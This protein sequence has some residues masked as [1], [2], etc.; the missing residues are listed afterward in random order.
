M[1]TVYRGTIRAPAQVAVRP[2]AGVSAHLRLSGA[3][4]REAQTIAGLEH[5]RLCRWRYGEENDR[6]MV[7]RLMSGGSLADR[8]Q[9]GAL[10]LRETAEIIERLAPALDRAHRQGIVHRDLKP[11]NILF[12]SDG[13]PYISDFGLAKLTEPSA[14][15]SQTGVMGTP[16]YMAPEQARGEKTIDGRA[17]LYALGVIVYQ[18]LTGRPPFDADTPMGV[19]YKHVTE[20]PPRLTAMRP[21]L[22]RQFDA[23]I[24][25]AM[26]KDPAQRFQTAGALQVALERAVSAQITR[27]GIKELDTA[28]TLLVPPDA[29]RPSQPPPI[30]PIRPQRP[31]T[32]PPS[33]QPEMVPPPVYNYPPPPTPTPLPA[34][35]PQRPA[36]S[37]RRWLLLFVL[38]GGLT[39]ALVVVAGRPTAMNSIKLPTATA[40]SGN[41]RCRWPPDPRRHPRPPSTQSSLR[42]SRRCLKRRRRPRRRWPSV[43]AGEPGRR[44]AV[45][46]PPGIRA[47]AAPDQAL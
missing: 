6:P 32:P 29:V 35:A 47:P 4:R 41:H 36:G 3:L 25:Q 30:T 10:P 2:A 24:T 42:Q 13:H 28:P 37:G 19:A 7:M 5:S 1:A 45:H 27:S 43:H 31:I 11:G 38:G 39:L 14:Q 12:D 15:L 34:V 21:D 22:P 20:A 17:D 46:V 9:G 16:A 26:A 23:L 40:A 33:Y 44:M 18:M 8:L